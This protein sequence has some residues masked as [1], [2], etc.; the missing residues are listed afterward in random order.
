[1]EGVLLNTLGDRHVQ[2]QT[3]R[4]PMDLNKM[5]SQV[6]HLQLNAIEHSTSKGYAMGTCDYIHF[7]S[8]HS[9]PLDSTPQTLSHYITYSS[10][11]IA[12]APK[13]LT[14]VRHFLHDIYPDFD[15][16]HSHPTV[17]ATIR[18]TKKT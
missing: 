1:M 13:Y 8:I 15:D 3:A 7:C 12:S 2:P 11:F 18:G 4:P 17:I 10:Q 16:N 9:L 14:G 6:R 5:D